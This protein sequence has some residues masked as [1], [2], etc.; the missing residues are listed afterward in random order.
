MFGWL[1]T[2]AAAL[3]RPPRSGPIDRQ[4]ISENS[5]ASYD[6][7]RALPAP[8]VNP[9]AKEATVMHCNRLI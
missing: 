4:R 9:N 6:A 1:G 7:A 5:F 8:A 2:P 3:V